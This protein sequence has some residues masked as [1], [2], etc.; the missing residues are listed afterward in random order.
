MWY[1]SLH[2]LGKKT[3]R[4]IP[5]RLL[6]PAHT[7]LVLCMP[8]LHPAFFCHARPPTQA[9]QRHN[10]DWGSL[11]S[12]DAARICCHQLH[13]ALVLAHINPSYT[14]RRTEYHRCHTADR[15]QRAV[16]LRCNN[17]KAG[18]P[19]TSYLPCKIDIRISK[20]RPTPMIWTRMA[21]GKVTTLH[22]PQT[23]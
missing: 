1:F 17:M 12:T 10:D 3:T 6:L 14:T 13:N 11:S 9:W 4:V 22:R 16:L 18:Y 7:T 5:I 2:Y 8:L 20:Y 21:M 19:P 15:C 23:W